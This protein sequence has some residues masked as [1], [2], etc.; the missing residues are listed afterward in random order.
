MMRKD[1]KE[2]IIGETLNNYID[3]NSEDDSSRDSIWTLCSVLEEEDDTLEYDDCS[4]DCID[5]YSNDSDCN[6][7]ESRVSFCDTEDYNAS[8]S[9]TTSDESSVI[10]LIMEAEEEDNDDLVWNLEDK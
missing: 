3:E 9:D 7:K 1:K 4:D 6:S 5:N 8:L 10:S 2:W